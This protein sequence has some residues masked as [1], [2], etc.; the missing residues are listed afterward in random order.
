M[1]GE[2]AWRAAWLNCLPETPC[3][4]VHFRNFSA[5]GALGYVCENVIG[6]ADHTDP[7]AAGCF[8]KTG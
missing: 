2:G 5:P 8:A 3:E 7:A 6:S 4:N 1:V